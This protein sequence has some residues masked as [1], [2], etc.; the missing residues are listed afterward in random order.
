MLCVTSGLLGQMGSV[1]C[2]MLCSTSK[3]VY[4][5]KGKKS[6]LSSACHGCI[7]HLGSGGVSAFTSN[8]SLTVQRFEETRNQKKPTGFFKVRLGKAVTNQMLVLGHYFQLVSQRQVM[9]FILSIKPLFLD[10]VDGHGKKKC[11]FSNAPAELFVW[12]TGRAPWLE[13]YLR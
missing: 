13:C 9:D 3:S 10:S 7:H 4:S 2:E 11:L 8:V 12:S 6:H 5:G 1:N